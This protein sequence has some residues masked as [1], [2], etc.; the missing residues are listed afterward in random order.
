[1]TVQAADQVD[2]AESPE[3]VVLTRTLL[4]LRR[5]AA[6]LDELWARVEIEKRGSVA[7][8]VAVA[9]ASHSVHRA[10]SSLA[11]AMTQEGSNHWGTGTR[12]HQHS[13]SCL[14]ATQSRQVPEPDH[15]LDSWPVGGA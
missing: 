2:F 4:A 7:M 9:E 12:R 5:S 6:A 15:S 11:D 14:L 8:A 1:M 3:I 10:L 13:G